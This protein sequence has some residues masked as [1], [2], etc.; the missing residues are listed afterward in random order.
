[1]AEKTEKIVYRY[2][3]Y[4][5]QNQYIVSVLLF[6]Q[7]RLNEAEKSEF[8][9]NLTNRVQFT[10]ALNCYSFT[11]YIYTYHHICVT[12]QDTKCKLLSS[13]TLCSLFGTDDKNGAYFKELMRVKMV[14]FAKWKMPNKQKIFFNR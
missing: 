7:V 6:I 8:S 14:T 2:S 9:D 10:L 4:I 13:A 11:L 1:M 3:Q 5:S 12:F